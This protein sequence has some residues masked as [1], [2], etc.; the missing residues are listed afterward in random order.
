MFFTVIV[1]FYISTLFDEIK[2]LLLLSL[3]LLLSQYQWV[4]NQSK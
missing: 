1:Y 4:D 2:I 3:L